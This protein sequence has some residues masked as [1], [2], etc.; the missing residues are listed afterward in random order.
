MYN[1]SATENIST[2]IILYCS[3]RHGER[4]APSLQRENVTVR[5]SLEI[6]ELVVPDSLGA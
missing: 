2:R 1:F 6:Q 4:F 3:P 5:C